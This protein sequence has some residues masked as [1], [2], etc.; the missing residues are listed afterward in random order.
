MRSLINEFMTPAAV[1]LAR[2]INRTIAMQ[3][4]QF[5][6]NSAGKLGT[7]L[8]KATIADARQVLL[9]NLAPDGEYYMVHS[10]AAEND[11]LN[12]TEFADA[13]KVD[14]GGITN[15]EA[16]LGRRLG[17]FHITTQDQ[18]HITGTFD[19]TSTTVNLTAG[20]AAGTTTVTV[21]TATPAAVDGAWCTIAG[22]MTPQFITSA[23]STS[24]T[25]SPG[26]KYAVT[27]GAAVTIYHPAL[28]NLSA[29]YAAY[30]D[31]GIVVDDL[32][33]APK[34]G[35]MVSTGATVAARNIYGLPS[36]TPTTTS[37]WLDRPLEAAVAN[38]AAVGIGPAG[39]YSFAFHRNAIAFVARPLAIPHP[40]TGVR[41]TNIVWN[42]IPIRV[43]ITYD[44]DKQGHLVTFDLLCGVK[45]LDTS[46]GCLVYS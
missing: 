13:D 42:G 33:N 25:F 18:P 12:I 26:L 34:I 19:K 2:T 28:V 3:G 30:Y 6:A 35:Q 17:F 15:K 37:L 7:T 22:D 39:T 20:Y 45:V 1:G 4:Y 32:T 14:D 5:F 43:T 38:D 11:L 10:P 41:A 31:E 40:S 44:G 24:L 27:D 23:V 16:I 8:T 29:G 36:I 21:D 46:L 9:D